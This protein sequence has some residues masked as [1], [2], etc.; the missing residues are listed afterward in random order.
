LTDAILVDKVF[1]AIC[2][3]LEGR[4]IFMTFRGG[5]LRGFKLLQML[6]PRSFFTAEGGGVIKVLSD[7]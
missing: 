7:K 6:G 4:S 1:T 2:N 3:N 5:I